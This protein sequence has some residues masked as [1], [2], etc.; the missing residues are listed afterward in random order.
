MILRS[1]QQAAVKKLYIKVVTLLAKTGTRICVF[2][3]PTGSGKTIMAAE[4]LRQL[5]EGQ[6]PRRYAFLWISSNNLHIQSKNKVKSYLEDSRYSFLLLDEVSDTKFD[7]NQVVFVNWESLTRQDKE[8]GEFKNVFMRD[9]ETGKNLQALIKNS[10]EVGLDIILIVDESHYHY[11]SKKSQELVQ[12][13]IAPKLIL[14]VSATPA[15]VP[16]AEDVEREEAGFVSVKFED[17]VK[18]GMIKESTV[19]NEAVSKYSDF[20]NTEDNVI[21]EAASA[22]RDQ[23]VK[24]YR[25]EGS[26]VNPL[27]LIQLPSESQTTSAL[28]ETKLKEVEKIL[29][30]KH[31]VTVENGKLGVW[32]SERKEHLHESTSGEWILDDGVQVLLFKQAIALGWDCPRAQILL[33]FRDIKVER[34]EIQTVGRI[35]R[36]AEQKHYDNDVL[37]QAYVFTNLNRISV[38]HDGTSEGYFRIY[39]A[40]RKKNYKA[41][42]LPSVYLSRIDFGDLTLSFRRLFVEE[43]NHYFG[44]TDKDAPRKAKEKVDVKLDLLPQELSK[45]IIS[46]AIIKNLDEQEKKEVIGLGKAEFAVSPDEIKRAY[47]TFA[48]ATSLPFAPVRSHTKIQQAIYDWFDKCL[49]YEKTSR[50]EIQRIVVC[51]EKNQ[52]IFKEVI[53]S[54]KER[55][56]DV[57]RKEK[58]SK[59]RKKEYKWNVPEVDYVNENHELATGGRAIMVYAQQDDKTLLDKKRSSQERGFED[60][61]ED[62]KSVAWWYKNGES[63]ETYFAIPYTDRVTG[64]SRAFYPDYIIQFAN[65]TIGIYD[66]K[67]GFTKDTQEAAAKSDA[68]QSYISRSTRLRGGFI[69]QRSAGWFVFTGKL[70]NPDETK[71]KRLEL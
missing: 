22:K 1:Y 35:M 17:V 64:F 48:K 67:S 32:L 8:T 60:L 54:A 46:D 7:E 20:R 24:L 27:L 69:T 71:W 49:G 26:K 23:L 36:M 50:L 47:E 63:K 38:A 19:I 58:Q 41:I 61:L 5:S 34:F 31:D 11:W 66:T 65:G 30:E 55:F 57:D 40:I 4:L 15:I 53:E 16:S 10:K 43:A 62:T 21:I 51:S 39:R 68:L 9:S 6:M 56:K 45:V 52:K 12:G 37:N 33:M 13:I 70:F 2:K 25:K 14:E 3:A 29:K 42:D 18:E 44:V 59:Q 28:D